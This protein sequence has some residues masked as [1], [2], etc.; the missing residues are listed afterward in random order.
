MMYM[1]N[2]SCLIFFENQ[3]QINNFIKF[4]MKEKEKEKD[5]STNINRKNRPPKYR[6]LKSEAIKELEAQFQKVF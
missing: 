4:K 3:Y 1:I 2:L 5:T 6:S